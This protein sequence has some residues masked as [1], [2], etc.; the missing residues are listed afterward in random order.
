MFYEICVEGYA[1][2]VEVTHCVN[3]PTLS[4]SHDSDWDFHG[5]R[6]IEFHIVRAAE[7]DNNGIRMAIDAPNF[8]QIAN[9]HEEAI[10]TA[11]WFEIDSRLE[12]QRRS[13]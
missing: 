12:R 3:N 1:L 8:D 4:G 13:R 2:Q 10:K 5:T 9:E 7:Y 6:E 11:L